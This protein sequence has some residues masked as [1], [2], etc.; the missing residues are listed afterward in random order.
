MAE[1]IEI[2]LKG[3]D[4]VIK[5]ETMIAL[6]SEMGSNGFEEEGDELKAY[7]EKD[8]FDAAWFKTV[9]EEN[10]VSYSLS[11]IQDQNWNSIW[12]SQFEPVVVDEF[13]AIRASFHAPITSVKYEI[14]ITPKMSFGTGHH[15]TTYM[16]MQEMAKLDF[17]NKEVFDFGTGTGILAVLAEKMG[18]RELLG[19]DN[20]DWSIENAKENL[21]AN[22]CTKI[23]IEKKDHPATE[24]LFDIILANINKHILLAYMK[25][26][27]VQLKKGGIILLSGLLEEDETDIKE[28]IV[29]AGITHMETVKREK[30]ICMRAGSN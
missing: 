6:L 23:E 5:K 13:A 20:D 19:I 18:A 8:T 11:E 7:V 15:A 9:A 3:M 30:W 21:A 16:M 4:E 26:L 14:V 25:D 29:K 22:G 10:G 2:A 12:E 28:A 17:T 1:Y 24:K 27:A